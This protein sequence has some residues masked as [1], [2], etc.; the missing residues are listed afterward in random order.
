MSIIEDVVGDLR[1]GSVRACQVFVEI[2]E[3]AGEGGHADT[4]DADE[5]NG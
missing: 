4:L 1:G 2:R 5:V 3:A